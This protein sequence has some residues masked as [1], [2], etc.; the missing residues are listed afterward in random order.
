MLNRILGFL[1]GTETEKSSLQGAERIQVA[2]C[3]LLLELAHAD[4]DFHEIEEMLVKDLVQQKFSLSQ[5]AT[6]DLLALSHE[7]REDSL[8]LFQFARQL[9][10]HFSREEKLE[11]V[12]VLWR[13]VYADGVLDRFED[14]LMRQLTTLLRLSPKE[15]IAA[16]L[17]VLEA[18]RSS[19]S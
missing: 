4:S 7:A 13:I 5:E 10:E 3:A 1:G 18:V 19:S 16:K 15:M 6:A 12:E 8:D 17:K 2:T 9:N 11:I 14:A